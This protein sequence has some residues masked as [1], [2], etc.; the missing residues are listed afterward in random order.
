MQSAVRS[1]KLEYR[2]RE[3]DF[4]EL[5]ISSFGYSLGIGKSGITLRY[6]G[7]PIKV[8]PASSLKHITILSD[9]VSISSNAIGYCMQ[10]Q[11]PIDFFDRQNKHV[12]SIVS[13]HFLQTTLWD[14]QH[15]LSDERSFDIGRRI[16][17]GKLS[18][19]VNL[20]K[21][22]SKYHKEESV[23]ATEVV[24]SEEHTSELQS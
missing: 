1:R 4:S 6:K 9:G 10:N 13:P 7:K 2:R 5:I 17:I 24:R 11:I 8:P 15:K 12:G 14:A 3:S 21:Y 20:I 16:I 19:Q 22:Y 18:N 23:V